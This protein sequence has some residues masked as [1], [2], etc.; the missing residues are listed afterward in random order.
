MSDMSVLRLDICQTPVLI[1]IYKV[2]EKGIQMNSIFEGGTMSADEY[3][4]FVERMGDARCAEC[5]WCGY[6]HN[7]YTCSKSK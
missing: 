3:A 6:I 4:R 7:P 2:K 5:G 1:F